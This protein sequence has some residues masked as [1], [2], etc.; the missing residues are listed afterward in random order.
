MVQ[1]FFYIL[2]EHLFFYPIDIY[3]TQ[4]YHKSTST[5]FI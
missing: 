2:Q 1:I 4:C 5:V 3:R